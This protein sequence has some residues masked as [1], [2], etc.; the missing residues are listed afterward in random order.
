MTATRNAVKCSVFRHV[1]Q[2]RLVFTYRY[3]EIL[4]VPTTSLINN[5]HLST[6]EPVFLGGKSRNTTRTLDKNLKVKPTV[7]FIDPSAQLFGEDSAL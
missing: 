2:P 1:N 5:E 3:V 4:A 6:R 7:K